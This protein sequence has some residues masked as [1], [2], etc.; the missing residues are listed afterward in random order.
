MKSIESREN[1]LF[2]P[3]YRSKMLLFSHG[4]FPK[5]SV[6]GAGAELLRWERVGAGMAE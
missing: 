5:A 3:E 6:G 4:D 2:A 1:V